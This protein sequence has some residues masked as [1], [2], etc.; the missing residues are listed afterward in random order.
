MIEFVFESGQQYLE[1]DAFTPSVLGSSWLNTI[2]SDSIKWV[3]GDFNPNKKTPKA[4]REWNNDTD[5]N[6]ISIG[7]W[8]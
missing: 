7:G 1:P 5:E 6:N 3:M 2:H 4:N 8:N